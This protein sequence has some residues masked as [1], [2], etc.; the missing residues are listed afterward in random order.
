MRI[1]IVLRDLPMAQGQAQSPACL[2]CISSRSLPKD[3]RKALLMVSAQ[4]RRERGVRGLGGWDGSGVDCCEESN[5]GEDGFEL[6]FK[7][8]RSE[9]LY[10]SVMNIEVST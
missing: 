7:R 3:I 1:D 5:E 4:R 6:R 2:L 10:G 8:R 9:G